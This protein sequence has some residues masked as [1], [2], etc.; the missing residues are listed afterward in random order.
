MTV[1]YLSRFVAW[2]LLLGRDR[3]A[4]ERGVQVKALLIFKRTSAIRS[5]LDGGR[6]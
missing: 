5:R 4:L 3:S 2:F 6:K 1:R